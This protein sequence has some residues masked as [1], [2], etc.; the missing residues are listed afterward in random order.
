[1]IRSSR[2][3]T[4]GANHACE[5]GSG[6]EICRATERRRTPATA[7]VDPE[8]EKLCATADESADFAES[9]LSEDGEGWCDNEMVKALDTSPT[10]VWRARQQPVE[11]GFEAVLNRKKLSRPSVLPIF[12]GEKEA[13]LI[14][15][16]CS[17]PPAGCARW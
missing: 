17:E 12:D 9:R 2:D 3:N 14:A 6:K 5:R 11:E 4:A 15:L 8:G 10:T 7:R 16:A 1:M 13:K